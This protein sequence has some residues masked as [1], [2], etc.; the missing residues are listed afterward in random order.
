M[1]RRGLAS[2]DIAD[3]LA[4]TYARNVFPREDLDWMNAGNNVQSEYNPFDEER[5]RD[6]P[7]QP[8]YYAPGWAKLKSEFEDERPYNQR[9]D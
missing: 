4:L 3:A 9:I 1:K 2:P 6:Q 8:R 7:T 5:M